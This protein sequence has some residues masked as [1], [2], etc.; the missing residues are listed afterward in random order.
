MRTLPASISYGLRRGKNVLEVRVRRRGKASRRATVR[1][2]VRSRS[3]LVGAGRDRRV[4]VGSDV[5]LYGQAKGVGASSS[6]LR[7]KLITAPAPL[8]PAEGSPP[9]PAEIT[10]PD[11]PTAGFSPTAL[12]S[13]VSKLTHGSGKSTTSDR[14]RLDAVAPNPLVPIETVRKNGT[15]FHGIKIGDHLYDNPH[16]NPLQVLVLDRKTLEPISNGSYIDGEANRLRAD[17]AKLDD[18]NLVIVSTGGLYNSAAGQSLPLDDLLSRIGVP[19]RLCTV[20]AIRSPARSRRS[21]S[22]A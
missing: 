7:W 3:P 2:F 1:F 4:V 17:I 6:N 21:A 16:K 11:G 18:T 13:Y 8:E 22:R 14:V 9:P 20:G 19:T 5:G 12:G 10:S 15:D